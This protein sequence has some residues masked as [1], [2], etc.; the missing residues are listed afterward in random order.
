M[1][2]TPLT[3]REEDEALAAE[4]VLGVLDLP[5]RLLVER[6]IA[7][8]AA[9]AVLVSAWESRLSPLND[10]YDEAPAPDLL[11][12]IEARLFPAPARARRGW[13]GWALGGLAVAV[14]A[15]AFIF[16][17]LVQPGPDMLARMATE[18]GA[19][20]YEATW[21]EGDLVITRVAGSAAPA[22][23]VHE[24]W[25]IP[26]G[27]AP[28]ALGLLEGAPLTLATARPQPGW[29]LAVSVE[30]AGGS[31]TGQPT[32]PVVMAAEIDA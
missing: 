10:G 30:P 27:G 20:A 16:L 11:P 23:Q 8:D 29:T 1:T 4:Y 22:G 3:P 32:G 19:I 28:V 12:R 24:L 18:D 9:F 6:R 14:A 15:L 17:P 21:A 2:D 7:Q 5:E 25:L 13:L 26:P 31:P